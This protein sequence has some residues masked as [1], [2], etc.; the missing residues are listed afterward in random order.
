[1]IKFVSRAF[2]LSFVVAVGCAIPTGEEPTGST[3]Q[4]MCGNPQGCD[5]WLNGCIAKGGKEGTPD[6]GVRMCCFSDKNGGQVCVNDP[7]AIVVKAEPSDPPPKK[8]YWPIGP[9]AT[10]TAFA[11]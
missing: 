6:Q 1:M 3:E 7:G 11:P 8:Q 5:S 2:V 9:I 10:A 4:A